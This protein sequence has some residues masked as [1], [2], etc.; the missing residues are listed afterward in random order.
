M[1]YRAVIFDLGGVVFPS[2]FEAFD[3][4]DREAGLPVGSTRGVVRVSSE[5]G[6]WAALERG[7]LSFE[8]FCKELDREALD[9]GVTIDSARMMA[10]VG[11]G[12]GPRPSMVRAAERIRAEGL[13]TAALTNNWAHPDGT[14]EHDGVRGLPS[15]FDVVVESAVE[16]LRKPDPAIYELVLDRLDVAA[17]DAVFLDDLGIN[18]K[19]ARAMGMTTIKVT[20]PDDALREL[21]SVL[22]F[23]LA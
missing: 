7:E 3:A 12:F 11:G 17:D 6:A 15:A 5:R 21:E 20:D 16:G 9:S 8:Q 22:G 18:L 23:G 10:L 14:L 2:P 4:Y 13:R 19:P 1:A